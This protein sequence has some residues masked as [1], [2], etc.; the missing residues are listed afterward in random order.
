MALGD[1][2]KRD[3]V[4]RLLEIADL[5]EAVKQRVR[6]YLDNLEN[7]ALAILLEDIKRR[8]GN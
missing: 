4:K 7:G 5:D 3:E 8:S 1:K 6:D 2:E